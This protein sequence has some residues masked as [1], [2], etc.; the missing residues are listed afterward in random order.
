MLIKR[1]RELDEGIGEK[2]LSFHVEGKEV[3]LEK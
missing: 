1:D 3:C 2:L